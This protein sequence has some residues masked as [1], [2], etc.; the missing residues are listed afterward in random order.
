MFLS[1]KMFVLDRVH[2]LKTV[3]FFPVQ[4]LLPMQ[5]YYIVSLLGIVELVLG[6]ESKE[7]LWEYKSTPGKL[8]GGLDN[9]AF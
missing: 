9:S 6:R 7:F 5:L 8:C 3:S 1:V 4:K 2:G